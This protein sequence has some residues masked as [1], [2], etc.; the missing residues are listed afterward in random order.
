MN[1]NHFASG[2]VVLTERLAT[3][4]PRL[5]LFW[6]SRHDIVQADEMAARTI[7]RMWIRGLISNYG[8]HNVWL[9]RNTPTSQGHRL[10]HS[11]SHWGYP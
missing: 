6:M 4:S 11:L 10:H 9:A 1:Q 8:C 2:E 3:G 7:S 5:W